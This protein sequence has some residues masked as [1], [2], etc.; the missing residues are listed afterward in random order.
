VGFKPSKLTP[1]QG[2][3]KIALYGKAA[4]GKTGT[5]LSFAEWLAKEDGKRVFFIETESGGTNFYTLDRPESDFHPTAFDVDGIRTKQLL[6]VRDF[7]PTIDTNVYGV[8]VIDSMSHFWDA[9]MALW[10]EEKNTRLGTP[11]IHAYQ[12][13]KKP[14]LQ[15]LNNAKALDLHLIICGR[16]QNDWERHSADDWEFKGTRM[17]AEKET[18]H[19]LDI[20][21]QM[22]QERDVKA[23]TFKIEMYVEKAT[24]GLR[25]GETIE[26][27]KGDAV[28]LW[29]ERIKGITGAPIQTLE[30]ALEADATLQVRLTEASRAERA[31]LFSD[32]RDSMMKARTHDD[33]RTAWTLTQGKKMKLGDDLY[34]QLE[35][36]KDSEKVRISQ[37]LPM[38]I[39]KGEAN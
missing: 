26:N 5:A 39:V 20:T 13:I 17:R 38:T 6:A 25:Q 34:E 16:E 10:P 31:K 23:K 2:K 1:Q 8:L 21:C 7:I 30:E 33:L 22:T 24:G 4:T 19:E 27:P 12:T 3:L 29:Y 35:A 32:I 11:P 15:L 36:V 9:A 37:L 28:R 14:F 18:G